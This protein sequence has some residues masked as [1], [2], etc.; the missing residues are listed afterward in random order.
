MD[1]A[2][3][4][5]FELQG[6]NHER[7]EDGLCVM[8]ATAWF[9]GE[10]HSDHPACVCPVIAHFCR[11]FNDRLGDRRQDLVPYIPRLVNSQ[12]GRRV[13]RARLD[14]LLT[15][16]VALGGNPARAE[17]LARRFERARL[18]TTARLSGLPSSAMPSP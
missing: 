1:F 7:P 4:I 17:S 11:A 10:R 15:D 18:P 2:S 3:L 9:A 14:I 6:G 8:E 13:T 16:Y 5:R 12:A